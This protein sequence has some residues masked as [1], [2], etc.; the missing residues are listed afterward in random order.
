[1]TAHSSKLESAPNGHAGG[2]TP[3][4]AGPAVD[5][6]L[7]AVTREFQNL[8]A[9]VEDLVQATSALTGEELTRAKVKLQA[10]VS[11]ARAYLGSVASDI[12]EQARSGAKSADDYVRAQPWRAIGITA[13]AGL[14]IGFLLGRR[15]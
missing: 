8:V 1:M 14:L 11:A 6:A 12:T 15:R 7:S 4:K 2:A 10:R 9:D 5:A 13:G 3:G